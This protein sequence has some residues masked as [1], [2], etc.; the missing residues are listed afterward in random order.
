MLT[1]CGATLG[2]A[3]DARLVD[4]VRLR[5]NVQQTVVIVAKVRRLS[6]VAVVERCVHKCIAVHELGREPCSDIIGK[7]INTNILSL[8]YIIIVTRIASTMDDQADC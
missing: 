6:F 7:T 2:V 5:I 3:R 4:G 8:L 1:I